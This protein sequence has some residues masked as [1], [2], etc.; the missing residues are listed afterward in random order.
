[1][2]VSSVVEE[3][4][5]STEQFLARVV[6]TQGNYLTITWPGPNPKAGWPYRSYKPSQTDQA[7]DILRWATRRGVDAYHA[8]ASFNMAEISVNARGDQVTRARREQTNVHLIRTLVMDADVKRDGDGKDPTNTFHDRR[9]AIEWLVGFCKATSIPMP[10]LAVNSGYGFHWY[11]ILEDP[12]TLAAWQPMADSLKNAMLANGWVGDTGPTVD[13]ARILRPP[14]TMNFKA[15]KDKGVPVTVLPRFTLADYPNQW[16]ADALAPWM[17][18]TQTRARTG[19]GGASIT[20]LGPRPAHLGTPN[21][22]LNQAAHG[23]LESRYKFS[24]IAKK[25][26]QVKLSLA[27]NGKGDPYPLWYLRHITLSVFTSDGKDF[28]HEFSRGDPR[29]VPADTDAAVLRAEDERDR[30]GLGAPLCAQYDTTRP[31]V[32]DTCPFKGQIKTPLVLGAEADDLP[33]NYRRRTVNGE[34]RIER[35][36]GSGED[37]EWKLLFEGDVADPRLDAV[38]IGGH[39]LTMTYRLA[40]KE[41]PVSGT[42][43]DMTTQIPVGYFERQGMAVTRHTAAHIGDFVMAWITQLRMR[44]ATRNDV[45]RPFGWNFNAAGERSGVAI[46][47]TL[48]RTDGREEAVAG[49]DPKILAMYRPAGDIKHWKRAAQLFEGTGRPDLQAI[50]ATSFGAMLISLCGDVRGMTLNFWSTESGVGKS[51]AIKVGQSVWGDYKLMQSM[52]DTPN[53]VMRSLSEPRILIRYWDELRV[54]KDYQEQFV[55]MIFTIPQG[56]ERARLHSDTTL[57][58]VGEWETMLVFTSNRPC[59]DYLLARDDGTDSGM[60]RV[61]EIEMAKV[62]TAY[63]PLAGQHIKLCETNYGH[64]GRVFAKYVATHLPEVQAKLATIL[65]SLGTGLEMQQD[66]RFSVTAMACTLVGA[67]IA[68]KLGLFDFDLKG[69]N[70]VLT[71]AFR[72]QREQRSTRTLVSADGGMDIEEIVNEFI[73]SQADYRLRTHAFATL[74][75][76]RVEAIHSPKGNVVRLQIADALKVVRVSRPAFQEWLRDRN[77]PASTIVEHL[78]TKMGALEHRKVIGAGTGFGGGG[79][80]WCLDIPL[81]GRLADIVLN[82]EEPIAGTRPPAKK[83]RKAPTDL[84]R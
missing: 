21:A 13:G 19:T 51:S 22:A 56:K 42:A 43:A 47:G 71:R 25:C 33:F 31:G 28:V 74:G 61:L 26:E 50:I 53:A 14:G 82:T 49:G 4:N 69:I 9:K 32:C 5:T 59:Q 60:A 73:Y 23:G 34:P 41:Y 44:Q 35:R 16:I 55:E 24:E 83:A 20:M 76:G 40:G 46:A 48:Y 11:W 67:A 3:T 7:A 57:R 52:Q 37:V 36:E 1:M 66:E 6:P 38:S 27:S 64:A 81:T 78:K 75:G 79:L 45:V 77:R 12:I 39:R 70:D 84:I 17:G 72:T 2:E 30:K 15:G 65:K 68:R 8:V 58:E 62:T 10:N 80:T 18:M 63:D 54:R 29:Y